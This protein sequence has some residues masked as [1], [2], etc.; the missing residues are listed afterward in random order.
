MMSA[1]PSLRRVIAPAWRPGRQAL[2]P[3]VLLTMPAD[4]NSP[5]EDN[6]ALLGAGHGGVF[7]DVLSQRNAN[8]ISRMRGSGNADALLR[9]APKAQEMA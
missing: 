5:L 7:R 6:A 3:C 2:V 1:S 9:E 4:A 8:L